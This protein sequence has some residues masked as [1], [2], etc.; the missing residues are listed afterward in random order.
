[1]ASTPV[2]S[3]MLK[4]Q[5]TLTYLATTGPD[6]GRISEIAGYMWIIMQIGSIMY[7]Y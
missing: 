7:H 5:L 4:V 6:H 1:M 2:H 3:R